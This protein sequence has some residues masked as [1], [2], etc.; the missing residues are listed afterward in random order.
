MIKWKQVDKSDGADFK[1][2]NAYNIRQ[3]ELE[4]INPP[5]IDKSVLLDVAT[6]H[7]IIVTHR[8]KPNGDP[9][10]NYANSFAPQILLN[11]TGKIPLNILEKGVP[12]TDAGKVLTYDASGN[13][14]KAFPAS[15]ESDKAFESN[16]YSTLLDTHPYTK[17]KFDLFNTDSMNKSGVPLP[18][19]VTGKYAG[20]NG[21]V[22]TT[23]APLISGIIN[24][25]DFMVYV[26]YSGTVPT[27]QYST[28]N[29]TY[30]PC[31]INTRINLTFN[32]LYFKIT[33]TG[34]ADVESFGVLYN[35]QIPAVATIPTSSNLAIMTTMPFDVDVPNNKGIIRQ[36]MMDGGPNSAYDLTKINTGDRLIILSPVLGT[37]NKWS[38][39]FFLGHVGVFVMFVHKLSNT[40][41][42]LC[43]SKSD[44]INGINFISMASAAIPPDPSYAP[45]N[46]LHAM[47]V[48]FK[49]SNEDGVHFTLD[50]YIYGQLKTGET[51]TLPDITVFGNIGNNSFVAN[52][53]I[54][55]PE[56]PS[57]GRIISIKFYKCNLEVNFP[58]PNN[59][60]IHIPSS[61]FTSGVR[62]DRSHMSGYG[63]YSQPDISNPSTLAS[64]ESLMTN[65]GSGR[66]KTLKYRY[67][68][69]MKLWH[70]IDFDNILVDVF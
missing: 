45:Q 47:P 13:L 46:K 26:D 50:R 14:V 31:S 38:A 33:W 23:T 15:A 10:A 60:T 58:N 56:N 63:I 39:T 36:S 24:Y 18:T 41:F 64:Y 42:K 6:D 17:V 5:A 65:P 69:P 35:Y 9:D 34:S 57:D 1:D 44:A 16:L 66:F 4:S 68:A 19:F 32:T 67:C 40:Q 61:D 21:S 22:I 51:G 48:D 20:S 37:P 30:Y 59:F 70:R 49:F 43:A 8:T 55:F 54:H 2:V 25:T 27:V 28:D 62:I 12:V 3:L 7:S 29:V 53:E 11:T 52:P